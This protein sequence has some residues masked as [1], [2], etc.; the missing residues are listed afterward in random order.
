M[1]NR[2]QIQRCERKLSACSPKEFYDRDGEEWTGS[3]LSCRWDGGNIIDL[4]FRVQREWKN[5]FQFGIWNLS[6]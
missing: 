5:G 3:E 2:L 4:V 1:E 6:Q